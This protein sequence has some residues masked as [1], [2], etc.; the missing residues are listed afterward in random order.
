VPFDGVTLL[1][2]GDQH[3]GKLQI[4]V[5]VQD[6]KGNVS[7]LIRHPY[8]VSVPA[9]K[10]DEASGQDIGYQVQLE[11]RGGTPKVAVTVWDEL[12][13]LQ[14]FVLQRVLVGETRKTG[15]GGR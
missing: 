6:E 11:V 4:F 2:N 9:D 12:S 1:P 3:Q 5:Q 13:G 10:V 15:R 7:P 14:S 8:P